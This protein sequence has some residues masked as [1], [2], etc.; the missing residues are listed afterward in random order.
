MKIIFTGHRDKRV[1]QALLDKLHLQY[2]GAIWVH[3]DCKTGFDAQVDRY[4]RGHRIPCIRFAP[5]ANT[6][7]HLL[8]RDDEM[9]FSMKPG[10]IAIACW[11][12]RKSGGT[13]YTKRAIERRGFEVEV[14]K[15]L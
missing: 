11:D 13:W 4:V 14:W 1:D 12:G 15:P 7:D 10:D 9:A 8:G 3:G 6:R 5:H 2:P